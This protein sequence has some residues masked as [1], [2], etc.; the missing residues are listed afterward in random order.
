MHTGAFHNLAS[1]VWNA[2]FDVALS[3]TPSFGMELG[4]LYL[5]TFLH[6]TSLLD[7]IFIKMFD[8]E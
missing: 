5:R 6:I 7:L 8:E 2:N 3:L 4:P 1:C